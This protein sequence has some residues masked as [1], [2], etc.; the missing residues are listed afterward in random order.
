MGIIDDD[1]AL[2]IAR[3]DVGK[4]AI[5]ATSTIKVP[6]PKRRRTAILACVKLS[7]MATPVC[8]NERS[9]TL[10][11]RSIYTLI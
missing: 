4:P 10:Q 2:L 7:L 6:K 5:P 1:V 3:D 11:D 9:P 8:P